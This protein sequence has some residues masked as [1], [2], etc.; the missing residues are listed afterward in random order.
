ME[1][2]QTK[3]LLG[4]AAGGVAVAAG[5]MI[6][7]QVKTSADTAS[8]GGVVTKLD[9][10]YIGCKAADAKG[11]S[12]AFKGDDGKYYKGDSKKALSANLIK[13]DGKYVKYDGKIFKTDGN[14]YD[15]KPPLAADAKAFKNDDGKYL[16]SDGSNGVIVTDSKSLY[17]YDGK[18]FAKGDKALSVSGPVYV[19]NNNSVIC[20][21]DGQAITIDIAKEATAVLELP[22]A[23]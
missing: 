14:K 3:L 18:I 8:K 23:S 1:K 17:K 13:D 6:Y 10:R 20:T 4:I 19:V 5:F 21:T 22:L 7:D 16:F 15:A 2:S 11:G 9:A 12:V